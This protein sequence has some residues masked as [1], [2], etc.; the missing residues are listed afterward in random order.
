MRE[1]LPCK[2]V[3]VV[4]YLSGM[5][6]CN[7]MMILNMR[8]GK[9]LGMRARLLYRGLSLQGEPR[10]LTWVGSMGGLWRFGTYMSII[11]F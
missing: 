4:W 6:V 1:K 7:M 3:Y 10:V 2:S 11:A 8:G 5:V 9:K